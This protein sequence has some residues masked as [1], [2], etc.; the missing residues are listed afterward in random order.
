V[1]TIKN[2]P[3]ARHYELESGTVPAGGG[4]ISWTTMLVATTKPP[5]VFNSL[6]PGGTYTFRVRAYGKLGYSD[7]SDP[8]SRM[9]I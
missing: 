6:T 5:T 3:K 4:P 1:V 2:V 9:C 7:W 8:V